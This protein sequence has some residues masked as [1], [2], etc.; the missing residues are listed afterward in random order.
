[1]F[2]MDNVKP[3]S[4]PLGN[5]FKLSKDQSPKIELEC[6]YMDKIPYASAIGSLMYVMVCTRPDIAH[7]VGVVSR[8]MSNPGKQHWEV[9]K[10]IMRFLKGSSKTCLSFTAGG[11]KLEGFVNADLAGDVDSRKSTTG[12]VYTLGGTVVSWSSTLQKII[13][14]STIEAEYVAVSESAKEIVWLQ[15]FL[16]ELGKMN[17]KGTLY[18]DSQ[19]AI[20]FAKNPV[21]HSRTKHIQIKYHFIR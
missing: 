5:H 11:L 16:K 13:A 10:W 6:R 14:F 17:G 20:F 1:M 19:S 15:S 18:S 9:V 7:A 21:F 4:T 8:Y 12:Y 2:S 3:V